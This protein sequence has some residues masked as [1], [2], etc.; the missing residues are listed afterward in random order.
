MTVVCPICA[1][2]HDGM[3]VSPVRS[4]YCSTACWFYVGSG[5]TPTPTPSRHDGITMICPVCEQRF[6]RRGRQRFCSD[7]CR[8]AAYR[9]RRD[10]HPATL[11]VPRS[12]PRGPITVYECDS[13]GARTLGEQRCGECMSFMRRVGIGG[14]CP[15]CDEP[16]AVAE[17]VGEEVIAGS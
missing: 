17:L 10:Q 8:A 11:V 14:S 5:A 15:C 3:P 6:S 16:V 4:P 9:R 2:S 1:Q 7:A 12:R 13:C